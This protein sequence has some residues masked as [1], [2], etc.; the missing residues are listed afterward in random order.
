M[1]LVF[2]G[3]AAF[4]GEVALADV[5]AFFPRLLAG[6]AAA[7][8]FLGEGEALDDDAFFPLVFAGVAAFLGVGEAAFAAAAFFP[9]V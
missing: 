8:A 1:P 9:L 2:A 6:V 4:L 3:V 7:A 5:F